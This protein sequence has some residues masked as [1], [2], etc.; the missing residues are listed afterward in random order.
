MIPEGNPKIKHFSAP[1]DQYVPKFCLA[2]EIFKAVKTS[3]GQT[4]DKRPDE[5]GNGKR[6]PVNMPGVPPWRQKL[7]S[8]QL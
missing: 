2:K 5:P 8:H 7:M 4:F 3:P 1:L 6:R